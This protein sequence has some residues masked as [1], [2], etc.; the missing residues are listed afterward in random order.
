MKN[1]NLNSKAEA[2]HNQLYK[3]KPGTAEDSPHL[4]ELLIETLAETV[5][6][7]NKRG[8]R[9]LFENVPAGVYRTTP[10]GRVLM[11][12]PAL[13]RMLG[14][15][16]FEE[17]AS[18]NLEKEGFA[19][20]YLRTQF[21][22][23]LEKE[24]EV[25]GLESEWIKSDGT[26]IFVRE[27][28]RA[29]RA[30]DGTVQYYEGIVEDISEQKRAEN[31][32]KEN[33]AQLS[34]KNRYEMIISAVTRSVH[35]SINLQ[36]VLENA[37]D[38]M[39]ENMEGID[40]VFIS[41]VEGEE[42]VL[43]AHRGYPEW[44]IERVR[45]IPYPKGA[46]WK[47]ITEGKPTYCADVDQDTIIGPAGREVGTKSY[48]SM[49]INFEG[50]AVG[51]ININSLHKNAFNEEE[52]KLLEIV[53]QQIEIAI[54]NARV[55]E[56]LQESEERYRTLFDQSPVG[57]YIYDKEFRIIQCNERMAQILHSSYDR[58][59]GLDMKNLKDKGFMP[60]MERTLRGEFCREER[61]YEATN[62]GAKL[63]LSLSLSPLC[64]ADGRV[65]AAMAVV[66]DITE[67]KRAEEALQESREQYR[68]L[69]EHT[70]D[71]IIE[72]D[73]YGH[74]LYVS[75]NHK[76]VLGY[77]SDELIGRSIFEHIHP[78]DR[79]AVMAEFQRARLNHSSGHSIFR[80]KH[81][82][83]EWRLLESTGKPYRTATGEIRAVIASRDI[84]ERKKMEEELI[85]AEKIESI[86]VLAGGI[87]H[88]F[89]NL[90]TSIMGNISLAKM[91]SNREDKVYKRL[92]ET[93]KAC[94]Q[95]K[96]LTQQL[97]TFSRGGT[98]VKK[99]CS[100]EQIIRD[101]V[102]FT[103]RGSNIKSEFS[104][105]DN[106]W[107]AEVDEGQITQVITNL[108]INAEQAMPE[109]GIIRIRA[110]NVDLGESVSPNGNT[111]PLPTGRCVKIAI[112]DEGTG[113]P[114][115]YL[116]KIFDP[117][118]TTKQK[119][120]GLGL[121]TAY[122]IIKNHNGYI[123]VESHLREGTKFYIYIPASDKEVL[124]EGDLKEKHTV[125]KGRVLIMDDEEM[126]REIT[127]RMLNL[128]GYEVEC[129]SGGVEAIELYTR[130]KEEN[131]S[132]DA[133][134][135]DLTI[136]G[137]MG[138]KEAIERLMSI[139]P[140]IRAIVS[141]GYSDDKVM[142]EYKKYGFRGVLSKPYNTE[143]LSKALH[144]VINEERVNNS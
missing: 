43:K 47:T 130:A 62:S 125:G 85:K 132:F 96:K 99:L 84:T 36:E 61:F 4:K 107:D 20:P 57:V 50:K 49:P 142:S 143:G 117:Y 37:V 24:E 8:Y 138:G 115:E 113:I 56:A 22:E 105:E 116:T 33:L 80:Y 106:L 38:A 2:L 59:V 118:F 144:N 77:D 27:S 129:A 71:L 89:N 51:A 31:A 70:Y 78:D 110:E 122:S 109:G 92:N 29:I 98:P 90:L 97:L 112:E 52:L 124:E 76:Q 48:L 72:T 3:S 17:L 119:G 9:D 128:I 88:D 11:A 53:A 63:W 114:E 137:G 64:D 26:V 30:Q 127:G 69:V 140:G 34:K 103:L 16:S 41:L 66:E 18:R 82:N 5:V 19:S 100:I 10:D 12:N 39:S 133:V 44:F 25:K 141:S 54:N 35:R 32:L 120:S 74:F 1:D 14:Y 58:I 60:V 68:I 81:K 87:A 101:S 42:A 111:M 104:I 73:V 7:E 135:M 95:A 55:A 40:N 91:Y 79:S 121:S 21:R 86:G 23:L 6:E 93:E 139:D 136:P 15:D 45:R 28:A 108:V 131:R 83:G 46:T 134:I 126:I 94:I 13:I 67:R 65:I 102:T 123:D 75:L